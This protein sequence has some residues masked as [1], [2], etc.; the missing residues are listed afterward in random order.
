MLKGLA[1]ALFYFASLPMIFFTPVVGVLMYTF[2]EYVAP[3]SLDYSL[4]YLW[5]LSQIVAIATLLSWILHPVKN[6]HRLQSLEILLILLVIWIAISTVFAVVPGAAWVKWDKVTKVILFS[7]FIP[8]ILSKRQDLEAALWVAMLSIGYTTIPGGAKTILSGGGGL[9]VIATA[10]GSDLNESS[11][12]AMACAFSIPLLIYLYRHNTLIPGKVL[13]KLIA[14]GL[15]AANAVSVVGTFART[16]LVAGVVVGICL[17]I[18]QGRRGIMLLIMMGMF[19]VVLLPL[20]APASWY[21]RMATI[22][23]YEADYSAMGRIITWGWVLETLPEHPIF[24]GGFRYFNVNPNLNQSGQPIA[25]HSIYFEVLGEQGIGGFII[26]SSILLISFTRL[27]RIEKAARR[28]GQPWMVDFAGLVQV[29][30]LG[31]MAGGAFI[32]VAYQSIFFN[33]IG[34]I[35]AFTVIFERHIAEALGDRRIGAAKTH[36]APPIFSRPL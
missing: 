23:T 14:L 5:P 24:G 29:S 36:L 31:F 6:W 1:I 30:L 2:V 4:L 20:F 33:S 21:E 17:A 34:L 35:I 10:S 19:A 25:P 8:L 9:S 16:G 13:P 15:I 18:K 3:Q 28:L 32:G 22:Q 11:T 27:R 12:V 7:L 26:Y